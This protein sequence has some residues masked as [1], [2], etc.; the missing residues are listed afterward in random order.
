MAKFLT[1]AGIILETDDKD[2]IECY[3]AKGLEEYVEN[4]LPLQDVEV[5]EEYVVRPAKKKK[6]GKKG[7]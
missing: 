5:A 7:V 2:K 4:P 6:G 1:Q 3:K